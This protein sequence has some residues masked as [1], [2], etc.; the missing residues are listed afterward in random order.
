MNAIL[1]GLPR[2]GTTLACHLLNRLPN[3]IA[4]SE[5]MQAGKLMGLSREEV[6][7]TVD[8][9]FAEQRDSLKSTGTALST[10]F[11]GEIPVNYY[12]SE[13][14]EKGLRYTK[15]TRSLIRFNKNLAE[16]YLLLIKHPIFFTAVLP[17]LAESYPCYAMVRNPLSL[18]L[19]WKSVAHVVNLNLP[20]SII[21]ESILKENPSLVSN[22]H[23]RQVKLLDWFFSQYENNLPSNAIILY[24]EMIAS[25]GRALSV[26]HGEA[27]NLN[28]VLESKNTNSLYEKNLVNTLTDLLLDSDGAY[29]RFYTKDQIEEV[30][31]GML[32][33]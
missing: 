5:P 3:V 1:T 31:N 12:G 29:W 19:S 7:T 15:S 4:L 32:N 20:T 24:E 26:I 6:I 33:Q 30:R 9:F 11:N 14:N 17:I 13:V 16:K 28:E 27:A 2:S 21:A 8:Q 23:A 10:G 25:G 18:L 22:L